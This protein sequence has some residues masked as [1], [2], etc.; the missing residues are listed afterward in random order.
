MFPEASPLA[1][2]E[3]LEQ[4]QGNIELASDAVLTAG[5]SYPKRSDVKASNSK[6]SSPRKRPVETD[7]EL[8]PP[9][10]PAK[11]VMVGFTD[12]DPDFVPTPDYKFECRTVLLNNLELVHHISIDRLMQYFGKY[13]VVMIEL[14]HD[15]LVFRRCL[16]EKTQRPE[17]LGCR[18]LSAPR[19]PTKIVVNNERL[20]AEIVA[21]QSAAESCRKFEASSKEVWVAE[22]E[23]ALGWFSNPVG[24]SPKRMKLDEQNRQDESESKGKGKESVEEAQIECGCC[25]CEYPMQKITQCEDGHLFC[26]EC[27]QRAADEVMNT[28]KTELKCMDV[29]GCK[30]RFPEAEVRRFLDPKKY[31]YWHKLRQE[32]EIRMANIEGYTTCPFC[33]F[34]AIMN[35][36][37]KVD[38]LFQCVNEDCRAVSCRLCRKANHLPLTCEEKEKDKAL[39]A[40]HTVE[41]AMTEALLRECPKCHQKFIKTDGCNKMRCSCGQLVCYICKAAISGYDHFNQAPDGRRQEGN[42]QLWDDL[43][44]RH[45]QDVAAAAQR[46]LADVKEKAPDVA[47]QQIAVDVPVIP[48][49]QPHA[50]GMPNAG[51]PAVLS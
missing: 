32:E 18:M 27:S 41:E 39:N 9:K 50:P 43:N 6:R 40:Q 1:L 14:H 3:T 36:D 8:P 42:C 51:N 38:K 17:G 4:Q 49:P 29:S 26:L 10:D 13:S 45:A 28:R 33:P 19:V 22:M 16:I 46:A 25:Y 23:N 24:R 31:R 21:Y 12:P 7:V 11:S 48:V 2:A 5:D 30:Y 15:N 20:K 47:V 35:T 37:P 44:M 34:G